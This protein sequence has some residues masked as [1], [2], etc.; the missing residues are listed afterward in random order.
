MIEDIVIIEFMVALAMG[1]GALCVFIWAVISGQM[2]GVEEI[3]YRV[4]EGET[5]DERR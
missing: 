2:E 4:L 5:E 3:K 1:L